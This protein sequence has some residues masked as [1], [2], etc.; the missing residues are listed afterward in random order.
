[1]TVAENNRSDS[2]GSEIRNYDVKI[3]LGYVVLAVALLIA[4]YAAAMS[5]GIAP[6]DFASMSAFP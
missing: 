2:A 3:M 5:S 6:G 1:M 4:I